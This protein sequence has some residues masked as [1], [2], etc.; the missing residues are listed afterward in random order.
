MIIQLAD[1]SNTYP[2]GFLENVFVQ[3]NEMV[4]PANFYV[5]DMCEEI[6][7]KVTLL[8]LGR[9]FMKT[10]QTKIDFHNGTLTMEFDGESISFNIFEAI[11]YPTNIHFYFSINIIDSLVHEVCEL[12]G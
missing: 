6:G 11:R 4:F 1:R 9:P 3:V 7:S 5:L 8:L 10:A 2:K 12:K